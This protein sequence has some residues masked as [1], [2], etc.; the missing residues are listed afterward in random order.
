MSKTKVSSRAARPRKIVILMGSPRRD[1]NSAALAAAIAEGATGAEVEAFYL[2]G[3]KIAPCSA[4]EACHKPGA[5]GCVL[6]DDMRKL[7][8]MLV[9][10]DAVVFASP[11]Y[12]FTI[13][14]QMKLAIDRCYAL[15]GPQG[16]AFAGKKI[17][18]AFSYGGE[19]P[20]DSGCT[21]A[22]RTFQ[23]AFRFIGAEIAGLVY[24]SATGAGEIRSN[25]KVMEEARALGRKLATA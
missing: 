24:G 22:I 1:G 14:A 10:A 9:A 21:N 6:R 25:R 13:S 17:G 7:Y 20:F 2:H 16:H 12:W 5:A 3:M 18:L 8:P 23:D 15:L 19:D 4:C 11:I